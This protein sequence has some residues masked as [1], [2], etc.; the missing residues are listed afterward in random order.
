[1]SKHKIE[2]GAHTYGDPD[3][4]G[5]KAH[6]YIGKFCSIAPRCRIDIGNEHNIK[7]ISTYPFNHFFREIAGHIN[8]ELTCR[9][10]VVIGNDVWI[11]FDVII[12]SGTTIGNGAVIGAQ[13]LVR[14]EIPPYAVAV[15]SMAK[16]KKYRFE[17]KEIKI[18]EKIKWWDWPEDWII[19]KETLELLMASNV[20]ALYEYWLKNRRYLEVVD[21]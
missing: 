20:G 19:K 7:N 15:G 14:G 5:K 3:V 4:N 8:T 2:I 1:M 17:R 12:L 6:L 13:S 9:G 16:V 10:D 11:G 21:V 18:L